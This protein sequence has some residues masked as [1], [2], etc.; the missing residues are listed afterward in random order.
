MVLTMDIL[1]QTNVCWK[2][3]VRST[4]VGT[5]IRKNFGENRAGTKVVIFTRY[6]M[7]PIQ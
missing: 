5:L 3:R 6:A 7:K 2:R 4:T 1:K